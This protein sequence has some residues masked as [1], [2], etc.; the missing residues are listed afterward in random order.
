MDEP[1][2][3]FLQPGFIF[4]SEEPY[5][6]QTVLG[7][8]V[9]VCL[10][11]ST[12]NMGGMNHFIYPRTT[13]ADRNAR[14]GDAAIPHLVRLMVRLGSEIKN[15]RAHVVGGAENPE[16][17][18]F[19]GQE[20]SDV[21]EKVLNRLGVEIMTRDLGGS[22]GRKVVFL[23]YNGEIAVYKVQTSRIRESDWF[24]SRKNGTQ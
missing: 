11:D 14:Y 20:N 18:S 17:T 2:R 5:Y 9:S 21:A 12:R 3:Y 13:G 4:V 24:N 1:K 6:I 8:C 10:W 22:I 23:N 16:F 19:I 7:S 15:L